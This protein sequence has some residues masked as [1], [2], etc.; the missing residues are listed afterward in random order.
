MRDIRNLL[1]QGVNERNFAL[2]NY[3]DKK[4]ETRP[5]YRFAY[6]MLLR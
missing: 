3:Q 4:G 1:E 2:V 6:Q 5:M